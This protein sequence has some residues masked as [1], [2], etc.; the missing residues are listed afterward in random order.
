MSELAR[1]ME[2]N[3]AAGNDPGSRS[4]MYA[5]HNL[6]A[7]LYRLDKLE[8]AYTAFSRA[9]EL[10]N[11]RYRDRGASGGDDD[12]RGALGNVAYVFVD[13]VGVAWDLAHAP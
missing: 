3:L 8:A 5:F 6:G 11:A 12:A 2:K 1:T 13:Q 4:M 7:V 10:A 9:S